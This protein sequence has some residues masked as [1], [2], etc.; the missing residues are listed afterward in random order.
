MEEVIKSNTEPVSQK[1]IDY[2]LFLTNEF[3]PAKLNQLTKLEASILIQ[4]L[5]DDRLNSIYGKLK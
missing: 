1:Q 4:K 2:I 3:S 5:K